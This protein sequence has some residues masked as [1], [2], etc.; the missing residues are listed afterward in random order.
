[1]GEQIRAIVKPELLVWARESAHFQ[2][3]VAAKKANVPV[4][5]LLEWET[6]ETSPTINQLRTLANIYKRPLAVFFLPEAPEQFDV[7]RDF[8]RLPG[9]VRAEYSPELARA[10][11]SWRLPSGVPDFAAKSRWNSRKTWG[12]MCLGWRLTPAHSYKPRTSSRIKPERSCT[13]R[14]KNSISG[15]SSTRP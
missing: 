14:F 3:H 15:R 1:M 11:L 12:L 6:G 10:A 9:T 2:P 5:R 7:M 8:R 13:S 4:E